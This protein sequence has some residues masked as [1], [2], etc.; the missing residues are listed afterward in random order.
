MS[1]SAV[2]RVAIT[3]ASG[4]I[5]GALSSALRERGDEVVHLVRRDPS[6]DTP[7]GVTEVRWDPPQ[8]L[9]E[10]ASIEG[11]DAV[12]HLAG[13]GIGDR[14]WTEDHKRRIRSSRVEGTATVSSAVAALDPHP[15]LVSGSAMGYYGSRGADVLTEES[16]NGTGFLAEVCRDWEAATWQAEQAGA[17]VAHTRMGIV[18]AP[19]GGAMARLLPLAKLGLA[20]P[21]GSGAQYWSWITLHDA[22]RAL[23]FLVDHPEITGPVNICAPEPAPQADV[24]RALGE[25]LRR[26]TVLRAPTIALRL[27]LGEMAVDILGSQRALPTV[28]SEAGFRWEHADLDDAIDWL[29]TEER[30]TAS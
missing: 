7:P 1:S 18:L 19:G 26:P 6:T 12:V 3:G 22:V 14:R 9:L 16:Q 13:A 15:R 10:P 25:H 20:G 21:L 17:P 28:L 27:A 29:L 11:V 2:R 23:T 5:G 4:L 24:V 8:G 30:A